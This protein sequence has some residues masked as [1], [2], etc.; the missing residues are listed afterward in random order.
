MTD[1]GAVRFQLDGMAD[2]AY[3]LMALLGLAFT[4]CYFRL[5]MM[6]SKARIDFMRRIEASVDRL[7]AAFERGDAKEALAELN[8]LKGA[9]KHG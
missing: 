7:Y 6:A 9:L 2:V 5:M 4:Y 8:Y 1:P 3:G